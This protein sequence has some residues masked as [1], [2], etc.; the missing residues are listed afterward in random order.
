[1][2]E[3]F[4]SLWN[5]TFL[6]TGPLWAMLVWMIWTSGQLQTPADRQIFLWV[7]IPAFAFI[8][9][10]GFIIARRHFK[11]LGSGSPR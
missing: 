8:Y 5:I 10:F 11:K 1:M 6:V 4:T 3:R 2:N 9:I 7:V